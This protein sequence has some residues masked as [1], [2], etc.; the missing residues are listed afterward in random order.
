ML[1][2]CWTAVSAIGTAVTAAFTVVLA[3]STVFLWLTTRKATRVAEKAADAAQTSAEAA[4]TT[5]MPFVFP[6]VV[7][8]DGLL[9]PPGAPIVPAHEPRLAFSLVNHGST[10][11]IVRNSQVELRLLENLP[12]SPLHVFPSIREPSEIIPAK[13]SGRAVMWCSGDDITAE[14][15]DQARRTLPDGGIRFYFFGQIVYDDF[16]GYRHTQG[17]CFKVTRHGW[18]S[19]VGGDAFNYKRRDPIPDIEQAVAAEEDGEA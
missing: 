8:F 18:H 5:S 13:A 17:F 19:V 4:V 6:E 10:P 15:I 2:S 11:A 16:F 7:R 12:P 1:E 3:F 9:P 14:Q